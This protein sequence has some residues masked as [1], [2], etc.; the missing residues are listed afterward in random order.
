[1]GVAHKSHLALDPRHS[2]AAEDDAQ[3][4]PLVLE[5]PPEGLEV[6]AEAP[7]RATPP[8]LPAGRRSFLR[9]SRGLGGR[10]V[11]AFLETNALLARAWKVLTPS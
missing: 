4:R 10:E 8:P 11:L 6:A 3:T 5:P 9:E 7:A 1:M 2:Q